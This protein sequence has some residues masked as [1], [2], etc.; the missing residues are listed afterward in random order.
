RQSFAKYLNKLGYKYIPD[1]AFYSLDSLIDY[2][3][4]VIP[5]EKALADLWNVYDSKDTEKLTR[6]FLS[7]TGEY[8]KLPLILFGIEHYVTGELKD[9]DKKSAETV[10]ELFVRRIKEDRQDF[11]YRNVMFN[12][13]N[14]PAVTKKIAENKL[15]SRFFNNF[16]HYTDFL[17]TSEK[18]ILLETF[19][20]SF[21]SEYVNQKARELLIPY[22]T[23]K[24]KEY[25]RID[26]VFSLLNAV[27]Y[28]KGENV[29]RVEEG[30]LVPHSSSA[31]GNN[32]MKAHK[33]AVN[34]RRFNSLKQ[35]ESALSKKRIIIL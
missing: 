31:G 14:Y 28:R 5:K 16:E 12:I 34:K 26:T 24:E 6:Y 15:L 27:R 35:D 19:I 1:T 22:L 9:W 21:K 18:I 23:E 2:F 10:K 4:S 30:I 33:I 13:G 8:V 17:P 20:E 7:L 25:Y 32:Y 29:L 11:L 3:Q